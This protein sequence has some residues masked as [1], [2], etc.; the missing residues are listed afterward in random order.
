MKRE[1]KMAVPI[2][3]TTVAA[4]PQCRWEF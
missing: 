4:R 3:G 2:K 1:D